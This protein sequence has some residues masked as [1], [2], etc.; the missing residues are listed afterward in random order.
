MH[1][2]A[3]SASGAAAEVEL[4]GP[5]L[6]EA[7]LA[8]AD[9]AAP[10]ILTRLLAQIANEA[11]FAREEEVGSPEDM[12]T[13]MRLGFNW[14]LGPLEFADLIGTER[15]LL[16]LEELRRDRGDAYRPAPLLRAAAQTSGGLRQGGV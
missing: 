2:S 5:T 11:A 10:E 16:L 15:A 4:V 14:P 8:K 7:E 3:R 6:D 12:D 13:A 1:R 9:P